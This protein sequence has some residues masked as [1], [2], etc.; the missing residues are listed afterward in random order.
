VPTC[1]GKDRVRLGLGKKKNSENIKDQ[2]GKVPA[3]GKRLRR[4]NLW[5]QVVFSKGRGG[6][7]R[8]H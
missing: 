7:T 5:L 3:G 8:C 1:G 2:K 6:G 4:V